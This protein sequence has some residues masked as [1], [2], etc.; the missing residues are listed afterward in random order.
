MIFES[1]R[2][3]NRKDGIVIAN[4]QTNEDYDDDSALIPRNTSITVRRLPRVPCM[5]I[6]FKPKV[7]ENELESIPPSTNVVADT[8]SVNLPEDFE[9]DLCGGD[10]Y[11]TTAEEVQ[12]V[13]FSDRAEEDMKIKAL[14]QGTLFDCQ[15]QE[16]E[17]YVRGE[18]YKNGVNGR[19]MADLSSARLENWTPP[20][21]YVCH[22]CGVAGH[23]IYHCPTNGDP[24]F[25]NR[26][27]GPQFGNSRPMLVS[28][29]NGS[30]VLQSRVV[31][32]VKPDEAA[33]SKEM[34]GLSSSRSVSHLPPELHCPLCK[35]VMKD[36]ALA[37][38][39]CFN[40]FCDKCIREHI[41]S[42][43]MCACG[44]TNILAD[45]L[46]PNKTIRETIN[47]MLES[48]S[49]SSSN[50]KTVAQDCPSTC[51]VQQTPPSILLPV[52]S[53]DKN[54]EVLMEGVPDVKEKDIADRVDVDIHTSEDAVKNLNESKATAEFVNVKEATITE[55]AAMT[56]QN[57]GTVLNVEEGE[58]KIKK[59]KKIL[60]PANAAGL[61]WSYPAMTCGP[62]LYN[63][64][65][66]NGALPCNID[67]FMQ[68]FNGATPYM[69]YGQFQPQF[70]FGAQ[71]YRL[72]PQRDISVLPINNKARHQ[73]LPVNS[74][75]NKTK[76]VVPRRNEL[77]E[78]RT[79]SSDTI[80]TER[81][82]CSEKPA[83]K[84]HQGMARHSPHPSPRHS[85]HQIQHHRPS[86]H[87]AHHSNHH[88][89]EL[90]KRKRSVLAHA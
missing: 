15:R 51:H 52:S 3:S 25:N 2:F 14:V 30:C 24:G 1:T 50:S 27:F 76:K 55:N 80:Q 78:T 54:G 46:L 11:G 5:P 89:K 33:F 31:A 66:G 23:F 28:S 21:G 68:G 38:K 74:A 19:I 16:G 35:D 13:P 86:N 32:S 44:A 70:L 63:Q 56:E 47:R 26:R 82:N 10:I 83:R 41:I 37:S 20:E 65:W 64:Y 4:A 34:D 43:S 73:E 9:L 57:H 67:Q 6:V 45:N 12:A 90:G 72:P 18:V 7:V 75:G 8:T 22:R 71:G 58:K 53:E 49:S 69:D 62:L 87:S 60:P 48:A 59:Q 61:Q 29:P 42:K 79:I 84:L 85:P 39:C 77:H 36:A 17:T 40:S 81:V 88:F